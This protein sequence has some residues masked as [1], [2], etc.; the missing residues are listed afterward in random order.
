MLQYALSTNPL[1]TQ[2]GRVGI[3]PQYFTNL[4]PV[5]RLAA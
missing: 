2:E 3:I 1:A 5:Q 4:L